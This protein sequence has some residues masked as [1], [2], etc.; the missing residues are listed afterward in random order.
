MDP[1]LNKSIVELGMVHD[2][3]LKNGVVTFTLAL[4]TMACPMRQHMQQD[5]RERLL[6]LEGVHD[7]VINT[8]EMTPRG[9]TA[10][11]GRATASLALP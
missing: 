3:A 1:D 6:D 11:D 10:G 9:E 7:V 2:V 4:T 5:A 8:R